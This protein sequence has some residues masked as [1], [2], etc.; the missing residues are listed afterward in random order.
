[1]A[2]AIRDDTASCV[3][4]LRL[5]GLDIE[6]V[7]EVPNGTVVK[8][9]MIARGSLHLDARATPSEVLHE[10]GHLATMPTRFR[11]FLDGDIKHCEPRIAAALSELAL[12]D[13]HLLR[14]AVFLENDG[15]AIAWSWAAG[16]HLGLEEKA[17]IR[18][19]DYSGFGWAV[20]SQ[21]ID[22]SHRGIGPLARAGMCALGTGGYPKL[23]R[24]LQ[25]ADV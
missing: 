5:I 9:V 21:L 12:P 2:L 11:H 6:I 10:A 3:D 14:K 17:V 8:G 19:G 16:R 4:F 18:D 13:D 24:W 25:D 22:L 7:D 20:R 1:M 15:P 23:L